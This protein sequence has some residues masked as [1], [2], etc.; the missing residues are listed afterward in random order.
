MLVAFGGKGHPQWEHGANGKEIWPGDGDV[1]IP[2]PPLK[3]TIIVLL[4]SD[5]HM[6]GGYLGAGKTMVAMESFMQTYGV[7]LTIGVPIFLKRAPIRMGTHST[8]TVTGLTES[9]TLCS[10][11][12]AK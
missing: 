9:T 10:R 1:C 6:R 12:Q 5:T 2:C 4:L 8:F 7:Q 11:S 3:V